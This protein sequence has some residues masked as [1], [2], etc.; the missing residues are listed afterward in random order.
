MDLACIPS[1]WDEIETARREGRQPRVHPNGFLQLDLEPDKMSDGRHI[2]K[3]RLHIFDDRLPRQTVR[4]AVHD[5]I[6]D[7]SSFVLKGTVLNDT[8]IAVDDEEGDLEVYQAQE[9]KCTET[10]LVPSG[11]RVSL[12]LKHT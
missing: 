5:H 11:R 12:R 3:R 6:F 4:T 1:L 9:M 10:N 2:A 7:M 8:Y